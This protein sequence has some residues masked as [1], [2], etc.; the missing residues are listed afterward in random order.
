MAPTGRR[1]GTGY[2]VGS[3]TAVDWGLLEL[4]VGPSTEGALKTSRLGWGSVPKRPNW[5][6]F[7]TVWPPKNRPFKAQRP[8][9]MR[10]FLGD[11][12]KA[13]YSLEGCLDT[14]EREVVPSLLKKAV[15][16]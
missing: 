1:V 9:K 7:G 14:C 5:N 15:D 12:P 8:F 13:F 6:P 11:E 10:P 4:P 16:A 2:G 3:F